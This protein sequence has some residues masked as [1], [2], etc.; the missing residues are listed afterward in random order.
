MQVVDE[1]I[2]GA[3][4]EVHRF[5]EGFGRFYGEAVWIDHCLPGGEHR[6]SVITVQRRCRK[7]PPTWHSS[8]T[9]EKRRAPVL[10][11]RV[12]KKSDAY[13]LT[14]IFLTRTLPSTSSR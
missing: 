1:R 8:G 2:A 14:I 11:G 10:P 9:K 4:R 13:L 7:N 3:A 12:S 5:V 6:E